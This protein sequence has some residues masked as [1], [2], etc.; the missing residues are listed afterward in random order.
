MPAA[1]IF[2]VAA[3]T[4]AGALTVALSSAPGTTI[5]Y[6]TDQTTPTAASPKYSAEIPVSS[7]ETI[8]AIAAINAYVTSATGTAT[9]TIAGSGSSSTVTVATNANGNITGIPPANSTASATFAYNNANRLASVTGSPTAATFVYDW[10]G[11]GSA[12]RMAERQR[13][14]TAT[15]RME[16]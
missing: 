10:G 1:P 14:S 5:Y 11:S 12:R 2:S 6:T 16:P 4:Y 9:Y 15:R 7:T 13:L 3:G 8:N